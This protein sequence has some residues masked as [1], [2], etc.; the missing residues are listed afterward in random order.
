MPQ[1]KISTKP[2]VLR[3]SALHSMLGPH[4]KRWHKSVLSMDDVAEQEVLSKALLCLRM[5]W[6]VINWT[7]IKLKN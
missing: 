1:E 2:L 4:I 5:S 6:T 7:V 3:F